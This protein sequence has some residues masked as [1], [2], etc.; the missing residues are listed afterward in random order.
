[1]R[2]RERSLSR[3]AYQNWFLVA[4]IYNVLWGGWVVLF[5]N[6]FFDLVGMVRPNY[7]AIWQAVGMMVMVYGPANYLISRQPE[8]YAG[9][10]WIGLAGKAFGPIGFIFGV[11][12]HQLPVV[13]GINNLTNDVIWLPV[14]TMFCLRYGR[15]PFDP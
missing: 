1:M 10:A 8:R 14:F 15:R 11:A 9:L 7:A 6:A 4:A 13:F 12:T 3:R 2:S 5:P